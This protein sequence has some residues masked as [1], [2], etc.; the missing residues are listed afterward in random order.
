MHDLAW[1][2]IREGGRHEIWQCGSTRIS[3]PRHREIN[4]RTVEGI[5]KDLEEEL[6]AR[7][8]R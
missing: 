6:G 7:W 8:W 3:I 2:K 5:C 4:E 1:E